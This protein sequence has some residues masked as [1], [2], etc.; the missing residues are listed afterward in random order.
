MRTPDDILAALPPLPAEPFT[1][2]E[3]AASLGCG[4]GLAQR[5]VYCLRSL[6]LVEPAGRRG[7]APLHALARRSRRAPANVNGLH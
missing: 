7:R 3:L 5:V 2:R 4:I 6:G 1:T